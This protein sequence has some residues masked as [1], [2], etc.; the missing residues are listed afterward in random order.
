MGNDYGCIC[1]KD[2]GD[3]PVPSSDYKF[4]NPEVIEKAWEQLKEKTGGSPYHCP[5]PSEITPDILEAEIT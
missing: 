3:V 5:I 2:T 4:D 1:S